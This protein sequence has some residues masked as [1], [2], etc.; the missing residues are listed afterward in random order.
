MILFGLDPGTATTGYAVA[1]ICGDSLRPITYGTIRTSPKN[2]PAERLKQIHDRIADLVDEYHP[3]VLV[4]ERLFFC[5]NEQTAIAVGRTLGVAMLLAAQRGI[6]VVEYT[7]LQV[8]SAVVGYGAAE[9]N[10]VQY[11]VQ[12]ILKL[13]EPPSPDDVADALALCITHAHSRKMNLVDRKPP[14]TGQR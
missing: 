7:P 13:P 3:E 2:L 10:Q 6:E 14:D 4:L 1:E 5:K 11:M 9:K 12:R 8:K